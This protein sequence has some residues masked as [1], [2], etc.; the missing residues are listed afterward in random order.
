ML[1]QKEIYD[2]R[3]MVDKFVT[4]KYREDFLQELYLI[5]LELDEQKL[6]ALQNSNTLLKFVFGVI[7]NQDRSSTSPFYKK[8]KHYDI[9]RQPETFI[10][11]QV[12]DDDL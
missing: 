12:T 7:R 6:L 4:Y 8:Y 1:T 11:H 5:I 10:K 2:I 9:Y 3:I